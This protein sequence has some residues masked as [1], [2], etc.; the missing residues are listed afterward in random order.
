[1]W[2]YIVEGDET[3]KDRIVQ[4]VAGRNAQ[5]RW[6][7]DAASFLSQ[8][9]ALPVGIVV[10]DI[11]LPDLDGLELQKQ[12]NRDCERSHKVVMLAGDC[13]I[14]DA[15]AAMREGAIDFLKK[16]IRRAELLDAIVR[17]EM[18]IS[19]QQQAARRERQQDRVMT[20]LTEREIDVLKASALGQSSKQVAHALDLSTRTV[21][22]H[23][24]N[25]IRKLGV[26]NF[27]S[28]LVLYASTGT[29]ASNITRLKT[30]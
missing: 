1:M 28:A 20:G 29:A 19:E 25:I 13:D 23:R 5:T 27:A 24:S 6:F 15:V 11:C 10:I 8:C 26:P 9:S 3:D 17:A 18:A 2:I 30:A 21:E 4:I 16:P 22:M 7:S 12:V 14:S